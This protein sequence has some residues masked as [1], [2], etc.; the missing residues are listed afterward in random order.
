MNKIIL[1]IGLLVFFIGI[2]FFAY[3]GL[4]LEAVIFRSFLLFLFT[5]FVASIFSIL[6]IKSFSKIFYKK[7]GN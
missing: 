1:N 4:P 5:T 2:I 3:R 6:L 7:D